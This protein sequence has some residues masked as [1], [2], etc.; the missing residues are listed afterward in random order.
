VNYGLRTALGKNMRPIWK[1]KTMKGWEQTLVECL[2]SKPE[3]LS[4]NTS[5]TK[6]KKVLDYEFGFLD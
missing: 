4:S 1:N 5:T 6:K 2:P 3:V